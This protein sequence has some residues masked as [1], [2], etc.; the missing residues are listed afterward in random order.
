MSDSDKKFIRLK[1]TNSKLDD[2]GPEYNVFYTEQNWSIK[3]NNYIFFND[4]YYIIEPGYYYYVKKE[5]LTI[6]N[7]NL[8]IK[9]FVKK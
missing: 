4:R 5:D 3:N 8:S 7:K 2:L 9:L 1:S 6:N